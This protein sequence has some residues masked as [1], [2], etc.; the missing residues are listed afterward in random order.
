VC[1]PTTSHLH[2]SLPRSDWL[3]ASHCAVLVGGSNGDGVWRNLVTIVKS[4][5]PRPY[6]VQFALYSRLIYTVI[7]LSDRLLPQANPNPRL[8]PQPDLRSISSP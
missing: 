3:F 7:Y 6:N 5:D 2:G 8:P 4:I 1:D